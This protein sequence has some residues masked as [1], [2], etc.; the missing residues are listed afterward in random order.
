[1]NTFLPATL[2]PDDGSTPAESTVHQSNKNKEPA[3]FPGVLIAFIGHCWAKVSS[4]RQNDELIVDAS[5][6]ER[7]WTVVNTR[8]STD[9]PHTHAHIHRN[10]QIKVSGVQHGGTRFVLCV[11]VV[12]VTE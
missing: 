2:G 12:G 8:P 10:N 4:L 9:R 6:Q 3:Q 7:V 5:R 11:C 1:M